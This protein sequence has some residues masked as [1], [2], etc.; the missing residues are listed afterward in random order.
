MVL[1]VG[2]NLFD[3]DHKNVFRIVSIYRNGS[4]LPL[5]RID[6]EPTDAYEVE[7]HRSKTFGSKTFWL[8]EKEM[9]WNGLRIAT[10]AEIVLYGSR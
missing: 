10:E 7:Y 4:P 8:T 1:T 9:Q 6:T 5:S 3:P 2:T